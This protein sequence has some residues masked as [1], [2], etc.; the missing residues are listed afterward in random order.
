MKRRK[1]TKKL[2]QFSKVHS[3]LRNAWRN[4]VEIWNL[5]DDVGWHFPVRI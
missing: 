2:S 5:D 4:L 1:K 3:Y